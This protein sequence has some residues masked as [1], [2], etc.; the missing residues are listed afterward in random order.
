MKWKTNHIYFCTYNR[1]ATLNNSDVNSKTTVR[2]KKVKLLLDEK[3][4]L[5]ETEN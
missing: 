4:Y 1:Q 3:N 5:Q 2:T